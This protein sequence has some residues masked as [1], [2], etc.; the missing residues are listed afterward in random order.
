MEHGLDSNISLFLPHSTQGWMKKITWVGFSNEDIRRVTLCWSWKKII[1]LLPL[2]GFQIQTIMY[3][4]FSILTQSFLYLHLLPHNM[5][6]SKV[7]YFPSHRQDGH[8]LHSWIT[9]T[10]LLSSYFSRYI[11]L[12]PLARSAHFTLETSS[13]NT[14]LPLSSDSQTTLLA[15]IQVPARALVNIFFYSKVADLGT[16]LR[17]RD[18][19]LYIRC[20]V[21]LLEFPKPFQRHWVE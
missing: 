11:S 18:S 20:C 7:S 5:G 2:S 6:T 16:L 1:S 9:T 21:A 3:I 15:S 17:P 14:Q 19:H 8:L 10:P 13:R 4:N 12:L